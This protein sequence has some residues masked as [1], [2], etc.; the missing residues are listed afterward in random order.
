[1]DRFL[2]HT[3]TLGEQIQAQAEVLYHRM[4]AIPVKEAGLSSHGEAYFTGSHFKRIFFSIETSAHLLYNSI[5]LTGKQVNDVVIMDYGA[6][7]GSLYLLAKMIG[8]K[9][10]IYNDLLEEW[11]N[12]ALIIASIVKIDVD[13]YIVGNI[14]ETLQILKINNTQLD[15][16]TSRNVIEHIYRL[17]EFYKAVHVY[18]P[19][20]IIYSSTTA[21]F[22]NPAMNLQHVV[23]HKKIE[24]IYRQYRLELIISVGKNITKK[25]A[26]KLA[27]NTRGYF[28]NDIIKAVENFVHK[29]IQP[30]AAAHYTNTCDV[31]Y[32]VWAENI[33]PFSV[34]K[35]MIESTGMMAVV[36]PGFWDTHYTK[37]WMNLIGK[38]FNPLIKN[39]PGI[40]YLLA[41]FIYVIAL[42]KEHKS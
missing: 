11:K 14:D 15:I 3:D 18:Q 5:S 24:K 7:L 6:G 35:K 19:Q 20:A 29:G 1:M 37:T 41:P 26:E 27:E 13:E 36:K 25:D 40:N 31:E 17:D 10:V 4:K 33:L 30:L 28:K 2:P 39:I 23:H 21:N 12:N 22:N 16:L 34:H 8:C 38:T 42:P 9:R 32:G